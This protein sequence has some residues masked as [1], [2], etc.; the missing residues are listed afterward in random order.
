MD[1]GRLMEEIVVDDPREL[2]EVACVL[3]LDDE[4]DELPVTAAA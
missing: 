1:I 2:T 3:D 4:R